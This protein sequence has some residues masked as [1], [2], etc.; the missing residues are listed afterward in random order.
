PLLIWK[1]LSPQTA[2]N[3]I[4]L[5]S[6]LVIPASLAGG[7]LGDR[8]NKRL[9]ISGGMLVGAGAFLLL[10]LSHGAVYIYLFIV[11]LAT[12]DN[13]G[14]MG[15]SLLGDY[16]GRRHFAT[17]RGIMAGAGSVGIALAPVYAGWVWD[18]TGSYTMALVPF[19]L[20]LVAASVLYALLPRPQVRGASRAAGAALGRDVRRST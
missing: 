17:L 13:L 15:W 14:V 9:I 5:W 8:G 12:F 19:A 20:L 10:A 1:G 16:F 4:G 7:Y 6:L 2:A 11:L 3:L 18:R